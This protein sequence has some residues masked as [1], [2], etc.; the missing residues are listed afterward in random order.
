MLNYLKMQVAF[1]TPEGESAFQPQKI[2]GNGPIGHVRSP[3]I[4]TCGG[5]VQGIT[6]LIGNGRCEIFWHIS[7]RL[8]RSER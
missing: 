3:R 1:R 4:R 2:P 5:I 7:R 6:R 8:G